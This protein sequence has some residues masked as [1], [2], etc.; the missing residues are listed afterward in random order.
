MRFHSTPRRA[1]P[2]GPPDPRGRRAPP[3]PGLVDDLLRRQYV[4]V[5][6]MPRVAGTAVTLADGAR[7]RSAEF[8]IVDELRLW[9]GERLLFVE[10][11]DGLAAEEAW[12]LMGQACGYPRTR[13]GPASCACAARPG[14][15]SG[16]HHLVA[17]RPSDDQHYRRTKD[18]R[19]LTHEASPSCER[20][21]PHPGT[22]RRR[23]R[24]R[25]PRCR[26]RGA[27]RVVESSALPSLARI[28]Y[29]VC[30]P[31]MGSTRCRLVPLRATR[32]A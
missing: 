26:G 14:P 32:P 15:P 27:R 6:T 7:L 9:G 21:A 13:P 1:T 18:R 16:P 24:D 29:R 30:R 23:C 5:P 28:R 10:F 25:R 19:S 20:S 8:A 2:G 31:R 3:G 17:R 11:A 22:D 12:R 4:V